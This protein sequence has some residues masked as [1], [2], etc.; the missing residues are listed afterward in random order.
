MSGI[1]SPLDSMR[2]LHIDDSPDDREIVK[3]SLEGIDHK[4]AIVSASSPTESLRMM[5]ELQI[6]CIVCDYSMPEM[7]GIELCR[8]IRATSDVPFIVYTGKGSEEVASVAFEAGADD[9]LRKDPGSG[10]FIVLAKRVRQAIEK[11]RVE[12]LYR[13][14]LEHSVDGIG[15]VEGT[16]I[17][18]ANQALAELDGVSDPHELIGR[19][20]LDFVLAED[21]AR[22]KSIALGRKRGERQP[23]KYEYSLL[24]PDGVVRRVEVSAS[25]ILYDGISATL[26]IIRDVT[27][28]VRYENRLEALHEYVNSLREAQNEEE[29][30]TL[31]IEA[32]DK[33]LGFEIT[34]ILMVDGEV[35]RQVA[36]KEN[37]P[38][39][40]ELRLD[41][42]GNT[43]LSLRESR[44]I[45]SPM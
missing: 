16:K 15:I 31:T 13:R 35:L 41:G 26:G 28:R 37:N 42:P 17:V 5:E 19:D 29:L 45:T 9:Y 36:A 20:S 11:H 24:R 23:S 22:L 1:L 40:I 18:Y 2:I 21:H 38:K 32:M 44:S 7:N 6:D 43:V 25:P 12:G 39:G 30:Y 4:M 27:D 33:A 34:D 3:L 8:K 14:V 10:H